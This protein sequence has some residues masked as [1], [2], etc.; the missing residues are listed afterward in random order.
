MEDEACGQPDIVLRSPAANFVKFFETS[1]QIVRLDGPKR[2][3]ARQAVVEAAAYG[4]C[5][6]S[7]IM[8]QKIC[9]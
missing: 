9:V 4:H 2:Q 6:I 8:A 3:A 5:E 7:L 1:Q